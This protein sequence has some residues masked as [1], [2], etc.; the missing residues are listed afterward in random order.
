M[1]NGTTTDPF[2]GFRVI[3]K[4]RESE[5]I[6]SFELVPPDA[7]QAP[8]FIPGQFLV[9]RLPTDNGHGP[10][11]RNYSIS[12]S[13]H[14]SGRL[15]ITV[16]REPSPADRTDLPPGEGSNYLHEQVDVG[17]VIHVNGPRGDFQL[18]P[19]SARPVVLLSGGVGL[20]PLVS[21]LHSLATTGDRRVYFV[22]ACDSGRV[23]ALKDEVLAL[24]VRR[25]GITMHFCYRFPTDEDVASAGFHS[26]GM[27]SREVLQ[28]IL[29]LDDYD[30]YM[31]GPPPFMQA[32][33]RLLRSFGVPKERIRY[34]FFG[35]ATVLDPDEAATPAAAQVEPPPS[36]PGEALQE[37]GVQ[38]VFRK[39]GKTAMWDEKA[40]SLL[41][42]AESLGIDAPFSCRAGV[43]NTCLSTLVR[44][45]VEYFEEPLSEP[46]PG[47]VLLCCSRPKTTVE[48]DV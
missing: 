27:I 4:R 13:P 22:H 14:D 39:S 23:H 32:N 30:V 33:Y 43:C 16:K 31:C 40:K 1:I 47:E 35:P 21:M 17:D 3:A 12:S 9:V 18:D 15:R 25:P 8:D 29:P 28:S 24:A 44:G 11:L 7:T 10:I 46:G 38:V 37:E 26:R 45:D 48:V 42:F 41:D 20:T 34:E 5:T 6:T 36:V 19:D 2:V